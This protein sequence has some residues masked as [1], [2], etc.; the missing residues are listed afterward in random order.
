MQKKKKV[1][2]EA[3]E[4]NSGEGSKISTGDWRNVGAREMEGGCQKNPERPLTMQLVSVNMLMKA[5][6][7]MKILNAHVTTPPLKS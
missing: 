1:L 2:I 4:R 3:F 6:L 7:D 5:P